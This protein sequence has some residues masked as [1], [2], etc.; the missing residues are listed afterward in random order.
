MAKK[1]LLTGG[2]GFIGRNI[3]EQLGASYEISCPARAELDLLDADAVRRYLKGNG[4]DA[5]LHAANIGGTR[6]TA[7]MAGVAESNLK[8]F[9][10]IA[11]CSSYF[12]KMIQL[13][14][15]AEYDKSRPLVRVR[16]E[17]FGKRAPQD[18]YGR[19]KYECS[20]YIEQ[21]SNITCL[22]IFGCFGKYEDYEI[23]FISNAICKSIFGL[24]ITIANK[25]AVFSY[26]Y[27]DDF[28]RIVEHFI[29]HDGA[30]KFYN[31]V[32]DETADLVTIAGKV[33][34]ISG[35]SLPVAVKNQGMGNAY[36]GDY[37]RL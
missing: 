5:V 27:I 25:N 33:K 32:P 15:G 26:L 12:G 10:N 16:E 21:A 28:V 6:K 9:M 17:E 22:R 13:G 4:F 1:I 8:C 3:S 11:Q 2:A 18:E 31:A 7:G 14:S 34:E 19:Y 37:S 20:K 23:R 24:P 29:G 30:H 36:T 35:S